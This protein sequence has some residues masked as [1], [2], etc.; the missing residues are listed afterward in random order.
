MRYRHIGRNFY[1]E[2]SESETSEISTSG[3]NKN[4][5]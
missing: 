4:I 2:I 5:S 1:V 3:L